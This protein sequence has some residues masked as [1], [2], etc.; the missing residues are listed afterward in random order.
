MTALTGYYDLLLPELPGCL[1]SLVNLHLREIAREFCTSTSVWKQAF[2]AINLVAGQP[3]YDLDAPEA[4]SEVVRVTRMTVN[5]VL[6]WDDTDLRQ[7]GHLAT[8]PK[9][10]RNKPPFTLTPDLAQLTLMT[11][12]VPTAST[13]GGL[14]LT[15]CMRPTI[16]ATSLPDFLRNQY[17]EA[18]RHGTLA[19]LMAMGKKPWTN[20]TLAAVY[21]QA[22]MQE[23]NFSAYQAQV[24]NTRKHLRVKKS[25]F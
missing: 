17:S 23:S 25:P 11:D 1:T 15:G 7:P 12:E 6:L 3:T 9:Y 10:V 8:E 14:V 24:G 22:Y 18:L 21:Q 16:T 4:N 13:T 2:D 5:S 19:R 20:L